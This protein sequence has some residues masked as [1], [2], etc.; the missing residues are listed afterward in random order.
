M[1]ALYVGSYGDYGALNFENLF[2]G[3]KVSW[4]IDNLGVCYRL[5]AQAMELDEEEFQLEVLE[6]NI[7]EPTFETIKRRLCDHDGLK[8]HNIYLETETI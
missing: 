1:K 3:Q 2:K 6:L 7:D 4:A 5:L 8:H